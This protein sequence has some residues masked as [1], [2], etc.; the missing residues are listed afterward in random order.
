MK[1]ELRWQVYW[2]FYIDFGLALSDIERGDETLDYNYLHLYPALGI[3]TSVRVRP[4]FVPI[5]IKLDVGVD[6]Y[7]VLKQKAIDGNTVVLEFS[8]NDKF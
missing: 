1:R 6:V 5:E 3:G 2:D 8:I 7:Q 4:R